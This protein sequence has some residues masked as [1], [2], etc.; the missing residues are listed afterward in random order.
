MRRRFPDSVHHAH[1]EPLHGLQ[2]GTGY[3][4]SV[5]EAPISSL[6]KQSSC[7][8]CTVRQI[9]FEL[10]EHQ[11]NGRTGC[12]PE[13]CFMEAGLTALTPHPE[14][15]WMGPSACERCMQL[16]LEISHKLKLQKS[17]SWECECA[18]SE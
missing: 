17:W 1:P 13:C 7:P 15:D 4:L 6:H 5:D 14:F 12:L 11:P 9:N 3:L 10:T 8:V 16:Q 18:V 2:A